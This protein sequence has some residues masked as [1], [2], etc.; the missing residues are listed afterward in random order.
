M[1]KEVRDRALQQIPYGLYVVGSADG[2]SVGTIVAN[3]ATQLSFSP[4]LVGIA[5]ESDSRMRTL[6]ETS[7]HFSINIL[8][9]KNADL[10]RAF[11]KPAETTKDEIHGK[12]FDRAR[13]G[14]PFLHDAVASIEC[15]VLHSVTTGDHVMFVGE[16]TDA[17]LHRDTGGD[18]LMLR[19]TGL[20]YH[21]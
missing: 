21:R 2:R 14:T 7:R 12:R 16:V 10:P 17:A 1:E 13:N 5:I 20:R 19:E 3:W 6:I 8:P 4:V 9:S 11:L 15:M 18:V